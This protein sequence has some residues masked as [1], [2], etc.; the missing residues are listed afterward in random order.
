MCF[1]LRR[2]ARDLIRRDA[3]RHGREDLHASWPVVA[4]YRAPL[5]TTHREAEFTLQAGKVQNLRLAAQ[6]VH[7]VTIPAGATWSFWAHVG[8]P[9]RRRGFVPGRELREG[10]VIPTIG[11]GLCQLSNAL[12][13]LALNAGMEVIERH[14]HTQRVPDTITIPGRD[15]TVFWNYVDLRLR[16]SHAWQ[17]EVRLEH[18][19]LRVQIR[20]S[21]SGEVR[22]VAPASAPATAAPNHTAE[23][24]DSC[25]MSG[26]F[27]HAEMQQLRGQSRTAWL[28]DEWWP[29][30][31]TWMESQRLPQD[32]LF[33]P[34]HGVRWHVASYRWP[35]QGWA[36]VRDEPWF[37]LR[38]SWRSRRLAR[39]GAARQRAQS[40]FSMELAQRY[41]R[42]LPF[43]AM[44]VV[45]S[46]TLL[47]YLWNTGA[48]AGRTF[49]VLMQRPPMRELHQLLDAAAL[50]NPG[51]KTIADYRADEK[52]VAAEAEALAAASRWITPHGDIARLGGAKALLLP[53]H[54]PPASAPTVPLPAAAPITIVFPAA[55]LARRG[56]YEVRDAARQLGAK[57]VL[58]GPVLEA[59]DFWSGIDT[60]AAGEN[61]RQHGGIVVLPSCAGGQPRRLL[62]ALSDGRKVITTSASGLPASESVILIPDC[63]AAALAD[64][65][66]QIWGQ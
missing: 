44:H 29:E 66:R 52:L 64:K 14:G 45:V 8:R 1:R 31:A 3:P 35:V 32:W 61:W 37:T 13:D 26:C 43:D 24:C 42:R 54:L 48:L 7:G 28:V 2:S 22:R 18:G 25:G 11:G 62:Q 50:R 23:S 36:R 20:R 15:A 40:A 38:R 21:P 46:Q 4:Q 30:F 53:W 5:F 63:D 65:I 12:H 56:C 57:V 55:T 9:S 60:V 41:A 59:E 27:R 58:G 19:E 34:L 33:L 17:I 51:S 10:C 47:P 39:E 16:A 49:D 6:C